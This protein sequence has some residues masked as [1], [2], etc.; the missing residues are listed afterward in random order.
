MAVSPK[1]APSR[2]YHPR[3]PEEDRIDFEQVAFTY[4]KDADTLYVDFYGKA[5]PAVSVPVVFDGDPD[6]IYLRVDFDND[7]VYGLQIDAF[8]IYT[9]KR[10][11][12]LYDALD[13]AT[14]WEITREEI[15]E[16][17][18]PRTPVPRTPAAVATFL[19]EVKERIALTPDA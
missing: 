5:F 14:L 1:T 10:H 16:A 18:P 17:C 7:D 11:P 15:A 19:A 2:T 4:W 3:W 6:G 8:L 13:W 12:F 9:A